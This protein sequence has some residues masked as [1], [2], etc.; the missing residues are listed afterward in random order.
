MNN[1]TCYTKLSF[2]VTCLLEYLELFK[3][4]ESPTC[5]FKFQQNNELGL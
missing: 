4:S 2:S 1:I 3:S 5:Y